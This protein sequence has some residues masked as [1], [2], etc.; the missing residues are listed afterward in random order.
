MSAVSMPRITPAPGARVRNGGTEFCLYAGHA[1]AVDLCIFT[2]GEE[3]RQ[4]MTR[5]DH[6]HWWLFLPGVGPGAEYG[7]RVHGPWDPESGY[8]FNPNKLLLDPYARGIK[9][10]LTYD[11]AVYAHITDS[12]IGVQSDLLDPRDSAPFVPRSVVIN[13]HFDWGDDTP[14]G[15]HRSDL[16]IYEA[17]VRGLTMTHPGVPPHLRGTYAGIAHPVII[18]HLQKLGVTSIELLPVQAFTSEPHLPPLGLTNY[19]GYNTI[20][21]FAP[22]AEYAA[23]SDPS[24]IVREFKG[25]VKL[26]HAAGIEVILDVVYNH[27]CEQGAG[28]GPMVCWRGIDAKAYYRLDAQGHDVDVTGC[29]NTVD[30]RHPIAM[31][32]VLDSLRYWVQEMHVD[33]FRFD[34]AVALSRGPGDDFHPDQP[35][36][37][38]MRTSSVLRHTKLIAEPWDVGMHGWRTG[39]FP[40]PFAEW[41][42]RF[43]DAART[44]WLSNVAA[45]QN[46]NAGVPLAE[47]GT[48]LAGS[49]DLFSGPVRH[50]QASI[51]M[52]TAHDGF[53]LNDLVSFAQKHNED[54][55]ENNQ[56]GSNHNRSWNHGFEGLDPENPDILR[57]RARS[58]RN[59]LGTLLLSA[60][61]PMLLA[62]D[63]L[64]RTQHG[65]NNAYSQDNEISWVHWNLQDWQ[66]DLLETSRFL[67]ELRKEL[68]VLRTR[69][70]YLDQP[71]NNGGT[72]ALT[73]CN[74]EGTTMTG[75]QWQDGQVCTLQAL[76]QSTA[77]DSDVLLMVLHGGAQPATVTLPMRFG[78]QPWTLRWDS[79][80]ENPRQVPTTHTS[81]GST[82][83]M[84]GASMAVFARSEKPHP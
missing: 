18:E 6:G 62:G 46:G 39:Q 2:N 31:G 45:S 60:G 66:K 50:P 42:D 83:E 24:E 7:F 77:L 69:K 25:M 41:N 43:R 56:D 74:A 47:L 53:T 48:R 84:E 17:H 72:H 30:T 37:M 63:E 57:L 15:H 79:R 65:N 52:V 8:R 81:P 51:N 49:R 82:Y 32:M 71:T 36:L 20:G 9:G 54:N 5:I 4:P 34:L 16:V 61:T 22:H 26:L 12:S 76:F 29:G 64:G 28:S 40:P 27:T 70:F 23:S 1:E 80:Y 58:R 55:G 19:W 11:P 33:G 59:L 21:F 35:L 75:A 67:T 68:P 73:W 38:A 10:E 3:N 78:D 44:F 14:P 13:E